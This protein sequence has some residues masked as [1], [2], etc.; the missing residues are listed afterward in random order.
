M[1]LNKARDFLGNES[2]LEVYERIEDGKLT[3]AILFQVG[4]VDVPKYR[5]AIGQ[6]LEATYI[7][8]RF[9]KEEEDKLQEILKKQK[10]NYTVHPVIDETLKRFGLSTMITVPFFGTRESKNLEHMSIVNE[11]FGF[12]DFNESG[13]RL[14]KKEAKKREMTKKS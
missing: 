13:V 8:P 6:F 7:V 5:N 10:S 1:A 11:F 3:G 14:Y 9:T 4:E 2:P 12:Q